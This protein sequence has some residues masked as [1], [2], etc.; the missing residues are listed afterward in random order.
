MFQSPELLTKMKKNE[1]KTIVLDSRKQAYIDARQWKI[2][3]SGTS[4]VQN[5]KNNKNNDSNSNNK[6][7]GIGNS[8]RNN[9]NNRNDNNI[10]NSN[11]KSLMQDD[12]VVMFLSELTGELRTG[13]RD[14]A[15][16]VIEVWMCLCGGDEWM[17]V[18]IYV[19][20]CVCIYFYVCLCMCVFTYLCAFVMSY[21]R[22]DNVILL[23]L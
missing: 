10:S 12:L 22:T 5:D 9:S 20:K 7:E 1:E 19:H 6:S 13:Q 8:N 16:W 18:Y 14:A 23:I 3:T 4:N 17:K 15:N 21:L 11:N 2:L